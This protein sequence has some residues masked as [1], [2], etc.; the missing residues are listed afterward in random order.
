VR[1]PDGRDQRFQLIATHSAIDRDHQFRQIPASCGVV[2]RLSASS[3]SKR[4]IAAR[5]GVSATA[6]RSAS[7]GRRRAALTWPLPES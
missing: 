3:M 6:A 4:Q 5:L 1:A 2:L 7:G